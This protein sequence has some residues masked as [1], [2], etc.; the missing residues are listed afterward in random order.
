MDY[1]DNVLG[2]A[3][4]IS[5]VVLINYNDALRGLFLALYAIDIVLSTFVLII[6]LI[7]FIVLLL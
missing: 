7:I 5:A 3:I 1:S 6:F 2:A 4:L